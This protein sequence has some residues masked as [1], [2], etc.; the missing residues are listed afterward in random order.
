MRG[1]FLV[2]EINYFKNLISAGYNAAISFKL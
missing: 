1:I 2:A